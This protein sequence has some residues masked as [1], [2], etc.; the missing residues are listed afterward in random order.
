MLYIYIFPFS[1]LFPFLSTLA[2]VFFNIHR[3]FV[4]WKPVGKTPS[5]SPPELC[6]LGH[7][8]RYCTFKDNRTP[9]PFALFP[10]PTVH[11]RFLYRYG[12]LHLSIRAH[13]KPSRSWSIVAGFR[14]VDGALFLRGDVSP[15]DILVG[16][17]VP[18]PVEGFCGL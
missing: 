17:P 18:V 6:N 1:I 10:P 9:I 14:V 13:L 5:T 12:K 11:Y 7:L 4:V 3:L 8:R 2:R 15:L 16:W